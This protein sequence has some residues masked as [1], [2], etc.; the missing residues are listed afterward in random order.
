MTAKPRSPARDPRE[1]LLAFHSR[2]L[3]EVVEKLR[4][5]LAALPVGADGL[6]EA[7][8]ALHRVA[9]AFA[10]LALRLTGPAPCPNTTPK[11]DL[12]CQEIKP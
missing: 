10:V 2:R 5:D 12:P 3:L 7:H 8:D 4:R 6:A 11:I 9:Q 1:L